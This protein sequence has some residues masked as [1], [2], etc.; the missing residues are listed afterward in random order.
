MDHSMPGF[1]VHH[2]LLEFSQT[3]VHSVSDAIQSSHPLVV[4]FSSCLQSFPPS[5]SFPKSQFFTA[6]G[7]SIGVSALASV[8]PMI[9][10][11]MDWL[12]LLAVQGTL[13]SLLQHHSSK[14]SVLWCSAFFIVQLSHPYMTTGKTIA[15]PRRIFVGKVMSLL[16]NILSILVLIPWWKSMVNGCGEAKKTCAPSMLRNTF[17]LF[18]LCFSLSGVPGVCSSQAQAHGRHEPPHLQG[19]RATALPEIMGKVQRKPTQG[20][21]SICNC[22]AEAGMAGLPRRLWDGTMTGCRQ[23][24][25]WLGSGRRRGGAEARQV[26]AFIFATPGRTHYRP[27]QYDRANSAFLFRRGK[28]NPQGK[29]TPALAAW[30]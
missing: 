24:C 30:N 9:S 6:G 29:E 26:V 3:R 5:G 12:D 25:R 7:Q 11:R 17:F 10:F 2:K 23:L 22:A 19:P 20:L 14:A 18:C 16:F 13:K 1:P 21:C 8:P 28:K 15:L 27:L 4:P